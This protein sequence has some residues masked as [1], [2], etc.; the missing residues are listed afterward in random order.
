MNFTRRR[1]LGVAAGA[2]AAAAV[3]A[4]LVAGTAQAANP[5]HGSTYAP[6]FTTALPRPKRI[7]L[8]GQPVTISAT[9]FAQQVLTGYP[10]TQLYG[11]NGSWPG[12]TLVAA[13]YLRASVIWQNKLPTTGPTLAASG[14]LLPVDASLLNPDMA[15]LPAG[16][17]PL[18]THLH[19]GHSEW[20]SDGHPEA[21]FTQDN[22]RGMTWQ[23]MAY[24]YDNTQVSAGLWYHDHSM[25]ITRLNNYAGLSGMYLIRDA[26]E[27]LLMATGVLPAPEHEVELMIQDRQFTDD[28]QL[29]LPTTT[30]PPGGT[31]A[32]IFGDFVLVNGA[33]W[34]VLEVEPRKYRLRLTNGSDGRIY[35]LSLSNGGPII[36]VG[37]DQG[38]MPSAVSVSSLPIAPGERYDIVV[39]F[40]GLAKG[41]SV[42]LLNT[43]VDGILRGFRDSTGQVT[44]RPTDAPFGFGPP[45]TADPD[46]TGQ[47][48]QFHVSKA[49]NFLPNASVTA[50]R[51]LA[52]ALPALTATKTRGVMTFNGQDGLGRGMEMLGSL[53]GGTALWM[54]PVTE[55]VAKGTTE[56][57]EIY[58]TGP[59]AHPVHIHLVDF[60]VLDRAPFTYTTEPMPMS[61]G[62]KGVMMTVTGTGTARAPEPYEVGR[63]DTVICYPGEVTRVIATFDLPGN[64]VWHCH[65]LHHEDHGMMRPVLVA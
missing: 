30:T 56:I 27:L 44:N 52:G 32:S 22:H 18:V 59:V 1:F 29:F 64:Y 8:I 62:G 63:K 37:S 38:L 21:W 51:T 20:E 47:V 15:A 14:H 54:D 33:P 10:A 3:P 9:Q 24:R 12:P 48:M 36:V 5:L 39:D 35:R 57:W 6:K 40:T 23:K 53:E 61:D 49:R 43:G 16:Q 17:K 11:Y 19:G 58:N 31:T 55:V 7:N 50:G 65:I 42:T 45:G 28:G 34:P 25:G 2:S 4:V 46:S 13:S 41:T 60:R 26:R